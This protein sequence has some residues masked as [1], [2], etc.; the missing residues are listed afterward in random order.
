MICLRLAFHCAFAVA[1]VCMPAFGQRSSNRKVPAA[2]PKLPPLQFSE[3][4]E[5]VES[6]KGFAPERLI[7]AVRQRCI[8]FAGTPEQIEK[9]KGLGASEELLVLIP[10]V[11]PP[12]PP[13]PPVF[14]GA[15]SVTCNQPECTILVNGQDR[16][17]TTRGMLEIKGLRP[18]DTYIEV[19]RE[20][21]LGSVQKLTL[22]PDKPASIALNLVRD[23]RLSQRAGVELFM[24]MLHRLGGLTGGSRS[25]VLAA[26]GQ[27]RVMSKAG[28]ILE[29]PVLVEVGL[30]DS[31]RLVTLNSSNKRQC[32]A[33]YRP[34][35]GKIE[36]LCENRKSPDSALQ[37]E[38]EQAVRMLAGH[39]P[40][41]L[42]DTLLAGKSE[43]QGPDSGATDGPVLLRVNGNN[44]VYQFQLGKDLLPEWI[45]H[46]GADNVTWTAEFAAYENRFTF[47]TRIGVRNAD[48]TV[49][50]DFSFSAV[51]QL[52]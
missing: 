19:R 26:K 4:L 24:K 6:F 20:G 46:T 29:K 36:F 2:K 25:G 17:R 38:L 18:E 21:Y 41:V 49:T 34:A 8:G 9:L 30:P 47:P 40:T 16:G 11:P 43:F 13:P 52:K 15:L 37:P 48:K 22:Q 33:T 10:K 12:P 51:N 3:L 31:F 27:M 1:L 35:T 7:D 23:P 45:G 42:V 5:A 32:H 14:A 39:Y 28:K 50:A 44:E